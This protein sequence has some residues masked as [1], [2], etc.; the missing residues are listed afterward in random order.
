MRLLIRST[1]ALLLAA[2]GCSDTPVLQNNDM[3]GAAADMSAADLAVAASPDL[4]TT[5]PPDLTGVAAAD[6]TGA[7]AV[8]LA[9]APESDLALATPPDLTVIPDLVAAP[10]PTIIMHDVWLAFCQAQAACGITPPNSNLSSC[11]QQNPPPG[12][13]SFITNALL[14]CVS[15]AGADC[16]KIKTCMNAGD[17]NFACVFANGPQQACTGDVFSLCQPSNTKLADD[18]ASQG[19]KCV[20]TKDPLST[21]CGLGACVPADGGFGPRECTNGIAAGCDPGGR[22]IAFED[23]G[24][25]DNNSCVVNMQ[26]A[27]SCVG[28]G[29]ACVKSSCNGSIMNSCRGG[30]EAQFDCKKQN[31]TCVDRGNG[32]VM[33]ANGMACD[34]VTFV[35][36][37]NGSVLSFCDLGQVKTVDCVQ[38]GWKRCVPRSVPDGGF[39]ATGGFCS[40]T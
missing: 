1:L 34:P 38:G 33:C 26:G 35:E 21:G 30:K 16:T 5:P 40:A 2:A 29:N 10:N 3:S 15:K 36:T 9:A 32:N 11:T 23:C 17:Q 18:C 8:D 14:A 28:K 4:A 12:Q 27:A 39:G 20:A 13:F 19:L 25:I 6:L 37:C 31:L 24:A 22:I 7:T